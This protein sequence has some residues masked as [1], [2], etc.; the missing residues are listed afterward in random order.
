M[1]GMF[2]LVIQLYIPYI[3]I[4]KP[5]AEAPFPLPSGRAKVSAWRHTPSAEVSHGPSSCL[6]AGVQV[7]VKWWGEEGEGRE[8]EPKMTSHTNYL[9][10]EPLDWKNC[11]LFPVRID[12]EHFTAYLKD[13]VGG[14]HGAMLL[15]ACS[16][17]PTRGSSL[18][19]V[20]VLQQHLVLEVVDAESGAVVGKSLYPVMERSV[21]PRRL[22]V[23]LCEPGGGGADEQGR[24]RG[25]CIGEWRPLPPCV[26]QAG[27]QLV[28][29]RSACMV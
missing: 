14:E 20:C 29:R 3:N 17:S 21:K 19:R 4:R 6:L 9:S 11:C 18:S 24:K 2:D 13:M 16:G 22:P 5:Q 10:K 26:S 12:S 1:L 28:L 7:R 15:S 25:P 27:R 23:Y 8:L